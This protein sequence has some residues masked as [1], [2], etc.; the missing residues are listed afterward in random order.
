MKKGTRLYINITNKCN[1]NC[2]FCCMYSGTDK[3]T[4]ITFEAFKNIIDDNHGDFELQLEGG[5][6]LLHPDIFLFISYAIHTTRC[7]KVIILSNGLILDEYMKQFV[8]MANWYKIDFELKLSVNYWLLSQKKDLLE[9]LSNLVFATEYMEHMNILLN[10]RKRRNID[11]WIDDELKRL[12][13]DTHAN[14]F[15][16]QSY[17]KLSES[18]EYGKPVIVQNID[19]WKIYASDG[20][21]FENDLIARSEYE[22]TL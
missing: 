14:S 20:T 4:F 1:T 12:K 8:N 3:S 21:C 10:V 11:E 22:R 17:G 15:Y 7:K 6:P 5:E 16:L 9:T 18:T 19:T 2:P 13:L